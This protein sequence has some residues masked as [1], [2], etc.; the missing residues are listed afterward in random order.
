MNIFKISWKNLLFRPMNLT[1]SLLLFA[2][3][4]GLASLLL[5]MDKQFGEKFESNLA[6]IDLVIGAK[7]SPLQLI[8]CNLFHVDLP[9]GNVTLEEARPFL[10]PR[11]P[12]ISQAIPL[13][14]GDTY[15]KYRI[16]G[17]LHGY[18]DLFGATLAEGQLWREPM[19]VTLGAEVASDLGLAVG[20]RFHSSHGFVLDENLVHG[21]SD[22]FR[23]T[24]ILAPSSTVLDQLILTST[25]SV[26]AVHAHGEE[27]T[28]EIQDS[29]A[30]AVGQALPPDVDP[31]LRKL[32]TS[33]G[34]EEITSL[35]ITFRN[36][37]FQTL[38]LL[39]TIN[40]QTG[41]MAA[42]PPYQINR[43]YS[44]MGVGAEGLRA[45]A[46]LIIC[47]SAVSIFISLYSS[48][49]DRKYELALMRVMGASKSYLLIMIIVEGVFIAL[50]GCL[51]GLILGHGGMELL[52]GFL[53]DAY[54]YRFT[55]L[56]FLPQEWILVV[57]SIL[58]GLLASLIPSLQASHTDISR[59]LAEG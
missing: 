15:R 43:L 36:R 50:L 28:S 19:E 31:M 29:S 20:D 46:Y 8:L 58:I 57:G 42:S 59:T 9:T 10:N 25:Q 40:E 30:L 32:I 51:A 2:L 1:L 11:H 12:L 7:G 37:N 55:G 35:L 3:G 38:N 26:W 54:Q 49:K 22:A 33:P 18:V 27:F 53:Q 39:R 6:G 34:E 45:L 14:L 23:V 47:V 21:D 17:T 41:M 4:I 44:M 48:L 52:S 13:S 5:Q 16:V 24:G 56:L